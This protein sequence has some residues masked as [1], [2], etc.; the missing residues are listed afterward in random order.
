MAVVIKI[1]LLRG[2]HAGV[3]EQLGRSEEAQ[4][5]SLQLEQQEQ[6]I[7][8]RQEHLKKEEARLATQKLHLEVSFPASLTGS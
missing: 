4:A 1:T 6:H 7:T 3:Q 2:W 5:L 8:Q